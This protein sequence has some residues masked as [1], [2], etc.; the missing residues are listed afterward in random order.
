MKV[1]IVLILIFSNLG[2]SQSTK[3]T[4]PN[5]PFVIKGFQYDKVVAYS[6]NRKVMG[7][8]V[9]DGKL[10]EKIIDGEKTLNKNQ[11]DSLHIILRGLKNAGSKNCTDFYFPEFGIVYYCKDSIVGNFSIPP[12][13]DQFVFYFRILNSEKDFPISTLSLEK[14]KR[15]KLE[16]WYSSLAIKKKE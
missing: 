3:T 15:R 7:F 11:I 4:N 12:Y 16:N 13:C 2:F 8:V 14:N 6:C 5:P 9:K 1:A 10:N